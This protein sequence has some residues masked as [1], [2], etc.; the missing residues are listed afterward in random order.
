MNKIIPPKPRARSR[1]VTA[2]PR[3]KEKNT[4][5]QPFQSWPVSQVLRFAKP[6]IN[7]RHLSHSE[8]HRTGSA[9]ALLKSTKE[10]ALKEER[11]R[12]GEE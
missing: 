6:T 1:P 4:G 11:R 9:T 5:I 8:L 12:R 7:L 10:S 3:E 2:G